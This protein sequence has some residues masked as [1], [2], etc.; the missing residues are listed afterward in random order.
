[1]LKSRADDEFAAVSFVESWCTDCRPTP[2][3]ELRNCDS[4]HCAAPF[5][6][7]VELSLSRISICYLVLKGSF[8][9]L[10]VTTAPVT[11]SC[12]S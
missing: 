10:F 4:I 8:K 6:E 11:G 9:P 12:S 2:L 1:M 3:D 7:E 5:V